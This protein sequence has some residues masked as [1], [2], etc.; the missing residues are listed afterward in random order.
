MSGKI[1]S[2]LVKS[3]RQKRGSMPGETARSETTRPPL[4][5]ASEAPLAAE[6]SVQTVPQEPVSSHGVPHPSRIWPD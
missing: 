6:Q 2:K 4:P 5:A 3:L 1:G